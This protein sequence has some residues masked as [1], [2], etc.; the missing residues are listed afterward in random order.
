[1]FLQ[2][3]AS[4]AELPAPP[5][6]IKPAAIGGASNHDVVANRAAARLANMSAAEALKAEM[7]GLKTLGRNAPK[8]APPPI[9]P[10]PVPSE[11]VEPPAAI[12][13]DV[14]APDAEMNTDTADTITDTVMA[15]DSPRGVKRKVEEV[16]QEDDDMDASGE[17]D[18]AGSDSDEAAPEVIGA[19]VVKKSKTEE[20]DDIQYVPTIKYCIRRAHILNSCSLWET[21]YQERYYRSKF[22]V[23]LSTD[24]GR[25]L[26]AEY[27]Q[28]KS[29]QGCD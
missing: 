7:S 3:D 8:T 5:S 13:D 25:K 29:F 6:P 14:V 18:A 22:E 24:E 28:S 9:Q 19:V 1:M 12:T 27:V 4:K 16:Q 23:E 15:E 2:T 20:H 10:A 21:G 17:D 26:L 11:T